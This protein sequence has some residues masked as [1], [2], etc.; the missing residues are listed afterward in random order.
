[1]AGFGF[2]GKNSDGGCVG[3]MSG[4]LGIATNYVA[5]FMALVV[6]GEWAIQRQFLNVCFGVDSRA[7]LTAFAGGKI[8]WIVLNRWKKVVG[9][10]RN[11]SFIHSYREVN[12]SPDKLAKRGANLNKGEVVVYM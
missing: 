5:E 3:A 1:M 4:G 10:L 7:I 9:N 12:F 2:I 6:A 8:P 11:T